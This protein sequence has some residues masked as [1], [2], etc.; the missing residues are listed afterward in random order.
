MSSQPPVLY[1]VSERVARITLNRPRYRNA[2]SRSLIEEL[3]RLFALAAADEEVGVIVLAG[4]GPTFSAG[5]DTGSPEEAEEADRRRRASLLEQTAVSWRLYSETAMRWRQIDK[6]TIAQVQG[7]CVYAGWTL[8]SAMDVIVCAEDAQFLPHLSEF[9]T[10]PWIVG[11]RKAKELLL[12]GE[13][14]SAARAY[15]LGMVNEVV[16]LDSLAQRVDE[17]AGAIGEGDPG[18]QRLIKAALNGIEDGMGFQASIRAAQAYNMM[19]FHDPEMQVE[20]E[21]K[22][23][24]I[25]T[26]AQALK[27]STG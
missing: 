16:P 4:N 24:E 7:Y 13:V 21:G 12:T 3:D 14:L 6:P 20:R 1:E 17:L 15:E 18:L 10:L 25:A 22:R 27:R 11:T 23:D 2:Q 9:F 26:A 19:A 8:A 5:H